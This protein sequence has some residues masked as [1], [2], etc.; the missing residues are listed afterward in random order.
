MTQT[1]IELFEKYIPNQLLQSIA[2]ATST[3]IM[4]S[5]GKLMVLTSTDISKSFGVT[6]VISY[7]K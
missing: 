4:A 5:T 3:N 1:T 7:L 2:D 6:L